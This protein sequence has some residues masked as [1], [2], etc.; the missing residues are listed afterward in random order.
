[1]SAPNANSLAPHVEA[2]KRVLRDLERHA[3]AAIDTL[4]SGDSSQFVAAIQERETLL[5]KLSQV[6]D[7]LNHE[8]AHA[9]GPGP[10]GRETE[11]TRALL[12]DLARAAADV[13][14]SH[15]RLVASA[16]VER[17]RLAGAVRRADKPDAVANQYAAMSHAPQQS[18]L[19]VTG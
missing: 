19:S 12:G 13:M 9:D 16:T 7:V 2:A 1:M 3:D 10:R 15:G 18:T 8:R 6:V 14:A 11:E 4:N 5:T 17:D